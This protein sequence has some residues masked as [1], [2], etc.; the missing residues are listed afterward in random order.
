MH[1]T[2]RESIARQLFE[3]ALLLPIVRQHLEQLRPHFV[4]RRKI[5]SSTFQYGALLGKSTFVR[6]NIREELRF[7]TSVGIRRVIQLARKGGPG[8]LRIHAAQSEPL[9]VILGA[10]ASRI[11]SKERRIHARKE[12]SVGN[13]LALANQYFDDH[14]GLN[15]L[16]DLEISG[17]DQLSV[18]HGDDIQSRESSPQQCRYEKSKQRP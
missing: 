5:V 8:E 18:C 7:G 9:C 3:R 17:R 2:P 4:C 12:F 13:A 1:Q 11:G 16:D 15:R 10:E 6:P 14:A